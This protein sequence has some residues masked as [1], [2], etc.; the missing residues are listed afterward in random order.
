[1]GEFKTYVKKLEEEFLK[2][3]NVDIKSME[4]GILPKNQTSSTDILDYIKSVKEVE[5]VLCEYYSHEGGILFGIN[6]YAM[7][8]KDV[9]RREDLFLNVLFETLMKMVG[10]SSSMK[11]SEL[12]E[13]KKTRLIFNWGMSSGF[14][15]KKGG[16]PSLDMKFSEFVIKKV[17]FQFFNFLIYFYFLNRVSVNWFLTNLF[18]SPLLVLNFLFCFC[19]FLA[20]LA[21]LLGC[22]NS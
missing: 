4:S 22:G 6:D 11:A 7:K 8:S 9:K 12:E 13:K 17:S 2:E 10:A 15:S 20:P 3:K 16:K 14:G 5:E 1:M 18:S 19:S 21:W